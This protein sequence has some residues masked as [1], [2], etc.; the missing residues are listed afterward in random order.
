MKPL[1]SQ[2]YKAEVIK[3]NF[4]MFYSHQ[5]ISYVLVLHFVANHRVW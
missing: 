3:Y 2:I 5:Y 1:I 4:K